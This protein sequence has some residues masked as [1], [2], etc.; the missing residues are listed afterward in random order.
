[1]AVIKENSVTINGLLHLILNY[2]TVDQVSE[3]LTKNSQALKQKDR[4][5]NNAVHIAAMSSNDN[6]VEIIKVLSKKD[7]TLSNQVNNYGLKPFS[8]S[9]MF[10]N[11]KVSHHFI[12]SRHSSVLENAPLK[13]NN[14]GG[15][16]F[17][18]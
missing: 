9:I 8:L 2:G 4:F 10:N 3:L 17:G 14:R 16:S 6:G 18:K 5:G 15:F 13:I 7:S 12:A 1:M 11:E